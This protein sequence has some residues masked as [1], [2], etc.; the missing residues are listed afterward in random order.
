MNEVPVKLEFSKPTI[1]LEFLDRISP[2][3]PR[4][5]LFA[6]E[7]NRKN[8]TMVSMKRAKDGWQLGNYA[9]QEIP[10]NAVGGSIFR[11]EITSQDVLLDSFKDVFFKI[12]F[13]SSR[14]SLVIPDNIVRV[15][16]L[17]F[18][19][20]PKSSKQLT[21]MI[22]WKMKKSIP[23]RIEETAISYQILGNEGQS[24]EKVVLISLIPKNIVRQYEDLLTNM[25][26]RIGLIDLSTFGIYNLFRTRI[27]D[28]GDVG[29]INCSYNYFTFMIIRNGNLLFVRCKNYQ[30]HGGALEEE[31]QKV[32]KRELSTSLSYYT[33]KLSGK[34]LSMTYIRSIGYDTTKLIQLLREG[35][36]GACEVL[37]PAS[38]INFS[39]AHDCDE[40]ARQKLIPAIGAVVGRV[41]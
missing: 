24:S 2:F 18:P 20:I 27:G 12:G 29:L 28:S 14:L 9:I 34:E 3:K 8:L 19:E 17:N 11:P 37:D 38:V 41:Q 23:Y 40:E 15:A 31:I 30:L 32:L 5:P 35:G 7:L 39:I 16:L 4:Y 22:M 10:E 25:N 1:N 36:I 6:A 13:R 21:D 26:V 33:E